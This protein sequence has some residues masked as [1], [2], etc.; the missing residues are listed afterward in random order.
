MVELSQRLHLAQYP[1]GGE[2]GVRGRAR[3]AP[4]RHALDRVLGAVEQMLGAVD[5]TAAA[6]TKPREEH[7]LG[8]KA[9][10]DLEAAAEAADAAAEAAAEAGRAARVRPA[11]Q[12]EQRARALLID[13][14]RQRRR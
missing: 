13:R 8:G 3:P 7:E 6:L 10:A 11:A 14:Q 4:K 12:V 9:R 2:L 1:L 5:G